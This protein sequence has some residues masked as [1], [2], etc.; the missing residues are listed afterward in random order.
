[1][2]MFKTKSIFAIFLCLFFTTVVFSFEGQETLE[3]LDN[4][5]TVILKETHTAPMIAMEA[6]VRA[7]SI[8]EGSRIG[9]GVSHYFEHMLFKGTKKRGAGEIP[10]TIH[11]AGGSDFNAY[12]SFERTV[13]HF[14]ILSKFQDTGLDVLS[15]MLMNSVF[16]EEEAEKEQKVILKEINIKDDT[17]DSALYWQ[18]MDLAYQVFP[19]RYPVIGY[20][21]LFRQLT[22]DDIVWYYRTMYSPSNVILSIAGD[23]NTNGMLE[24]VKNYFGSWKRQ[25]V[26]MISLPEEPEQVNYRFREVEGD[27]K[28]ARIMMV[29]HTIPLMHKDLYALD[30]LSYILGAGQTSRLHKRL[31][32][33][34]KLAHTI[35]SNSWTPQYPGLFNIKA[36]IDE[37]NYTKAKFAVFDEINKFKY[38]LV[39]RDELEKVKNNVLAG[40]IFSKETISAQASSL[41]SSY[42]HTGTLDFDD[43]YI[44]GIKNVR[45]EDIKRV[46]KKYL[47]NDNL[48]LI[49]MK[50][51][52]EKTQIASTSN[53]FRKNDEVRRITL[54]NGAVILLMEDHKLPIISANAGF[55]AGVRLENEKNNGISNLA[56]S[57]LTKGTKRYSKERIQKIVDNTGSD[58][59]ASSGN[60]TIFVSTKMLKDNFDQIW[61]VF[62][63]VLSENKFKQEDFDNLKERTIAGIKQSMED[64]NYRSDLLWRK[65]V[66]SGHAYSMSKSG[67]L[68]SVQ[69]I[70]SNQVREFIS[71][72]IVPSNMTL[73]IVGDFNMKE[74]EKNIKDTIGNFKKIKFKKPPKREADEI[75]G[76]K[77]FR[78]TMKGKKQCVVRFGF[79]GVDVLHDDKYV[80]NVMSSILSGL[81]SRLFENLRSKHS[82]AY[83]VYSFAFN[84]LDTGAYAFYIAT[85]PEKKEFAIEKIWE[86]IERLKK[87]PVTDAELERAKNKL[88][89]GHAGSMQSTLGVAQELVLDDMYDIGYKE[90]FEYTAKIQ[91]ITKKDIMRV[92]KKYLNKNACVITVVEPEV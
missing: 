7:G 50:P 17:P 48:S 20:E 56:A 11:S 57:M 87:E 65:K 90:A 72:Y 35:Y 32:E 27:V 81:G 15:D 39:K 37:E 64:I 86:E 42:F 40:T 85:V 84:G 73:A 16:D 71:D 47:H 89:G 24:K 59:S 36:F 1:V 70:D 75:R 44:R 26:P 83:S 79:R 12:T 46:A 91:R 52:K 66:F 13:Y 4:G 19:Y 29:Y 53:A 82:L 77:E 69:S 2:I 34:E 28:I 60:N 49:Y 92:A 54:E 8:T 5:L 21:N 67:T 62:V 14:T 25:M 22:R 31:I 74:M 55:L 30:C 51:K 88:T 3:T 45:P 33:D 41:A 9:S 61:P 68:E 63:S 10:Q 43:R 76:L 58:L 23:F 78:D 80:M 18:M 38:E 6:W